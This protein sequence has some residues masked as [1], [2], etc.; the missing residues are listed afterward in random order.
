MKKNISFLVV[1]LSFIIVNAQSVKKGFKDYRDFSYKESVKELLKSAEGENPSYEVL[2]TLSNAY[3]LNNDM[4]NASKWY[5]VLA[6]KNEEL[7]AELYYRYAMSLKSM[8]EY[9]EANKWLEKFAEATPDDSRAKLFKSASDY[10]EKIEE[11]SGN[12]ELEDVDFNT[13]KSDFGASFYK[14]GIVFAS[15]RGEGE[16]YKWNEQPFLDLYYKAN[17]SEKAEL[18]SYD[19]NTGFHE[20]STSFSKDGKTIYFTRNNYHNGVERKNRERVTGLKIYRATLIGDY[21]TNIIPMP[22]NSDDYN[23]AHPALSPDGTKLYFAS[24]MYGTQGKSD[25]YVVDVTDNLGN[26]SYSAPRNLGEAINTS[27]REN[28]PFV[29]DNGVL[30]FSSDGHPGLGGLDV[31]KVNVF[32]DGAKPINV[33]RPVN[34]PKDDFEF[35]IDDATEEGYFTSNRE[36]GLGDDDI[37]KIKAY[38]CE[39]EVSGTVVD[40]ETKEAIADATVII[41]NEEDEEV[42]SLTSDEEGKFSY[43][44]DCKSEANYKIKVEKGDYEAFD[45]TFTIEAKND[46][47][48]TIKVPLVAPEPEVKAAEV[49]TDLF[50]LLNMKP[51]YFDV[52]KAKIRPDAQVELQKVINYMKEFPSVKI[53]VRSHTDSRGSDAYNLALSKKRNTSTKNWIITKGG[54]EPARISGQ[55]YGETKLVNRCKN[56]VKCSKMEHEAN[57]RSE[58]I[59]TA[60]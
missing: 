30:Y 22:F 7:P 58:F 56:G 49:G 57:R 16:I 40:S 53:D 54:I 43:K 13:D 12:Y 45:E 17:G 38:S 35:I 36:D 9:E 18:F 25:I 29:S 47:P 14:D 37:Y 60:N 46:F 26:I 42:E 44:T 39:T 32:E 23:V 21:W 48:I 34:S 24:D 31:F 59:V 41:L 55:G 20:S 10:L 3:Y 6:A 15:S 5:G 11:L 1:L 19:I 50:K 51:I 28:F 33:G 4:E 2:E 52:N 27:G 8:S